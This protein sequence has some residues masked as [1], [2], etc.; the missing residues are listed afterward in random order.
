MRSVPSCAPDTMQPPGSACAR[1]V[2][3]STG[4]WF[5]G[6]RQV[7]SCLPCDDEVC[8]HRDLQRDDS[9]TVRRQDSR[10]NTRGFKAHHRVLS[11]SKPPYLERAV[12]AARHDRVRLA[13]GKQRDCPAGGA[14]IAATAVEGEGPPPAT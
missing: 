8:V 12:A 13:H 1:R 11:Q 3:P 10:P 7:Y 14:A 5:T 4:G 2:G 6:H 9:A